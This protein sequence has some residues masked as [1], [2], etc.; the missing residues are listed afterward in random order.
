MTK[1]FILKINKVDPDPPT[2]VSSYRAPRHQKSIEY[3]AS[4]E[5][6]DRR[7]AEVYDGLKKLVGFFDGVEV[8][9]SE[10]EVLP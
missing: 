2:I 10:A 4:R 6:A 5:G 8:E 3:Y 7:R 1:I 9:I